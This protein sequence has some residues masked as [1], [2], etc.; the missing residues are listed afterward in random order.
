[1]TCDVVS[2]YTS[3]PHELGVESIEFWLKES[4][5]TIPTRFMHSF[6][7]QAIDFILK[8]NYF[9]FE[10][11]FYL[12]I[13]GTAM[14]TKM[15]PTYA[16]LVMGYL[17]TKMYSKIKEVYPNDV[18]EHILNSWLRYI[19]DGWLIWNHS[20][21]SI[22]GFVNILNNLHH[23]IKFTIEHSDAEIHFLD[24]LVSFGDNNTI[25]TDIYHKSTDSFNYVPF[26][27]NHPRHTLKN[28]P[29]VLSHR[30][31]QIV[32]DEEIR[33]ERYAT[34][35]CHLLRL[36]YPNTL[37]NDAIDKAQKPEEENKKQENM[38]K[39]V[40]P[41]IQTL[42]PNNPPIFDKILLPISF[43]LQTIDSFKNC[44]FR[45]SF[46]QP[47]SL[48]SK[49][50]KSKRI[51]ITGIV[52]CGEN[53][54]RCCSHILVCT[55]VSFKIDSATHNFTLKHNFNCHSHNLIYKL[56]CNGCGEYYIGQTGDSLKH[57]MTVHRQQINNPNYSFLRVS[58]HI[59]TCAN[60]KDVKFLVAPFYKMSPSSTKLDREKKE[61][62]FIKKFK[63][64]LNG[65]LL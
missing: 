56:T 5:N 20:F 26:T 49:L 54:C 35:K 22:D 65:H 1:M 9:S 24:V 15:A 61:D 8:N 10:D 62:L 50:T 43:S 63:P 60:T 57:R 19:D 39:K 37:I 41:F 51:T 11:D 16:C 28:I 34:L 53:Q 33:A 52:K 42:N 44:A 17:E 47:N 4:P 7:L 6:I 12:Q 18:Y 48:L 38:N 40:I 58:K 25:K 29:Y 46:R 27:S 13:S 21:G 23:S 31:Q 45:R 55:V 59:R 32:S 14:G 2:L 64:S 30:I 3:I 36:K